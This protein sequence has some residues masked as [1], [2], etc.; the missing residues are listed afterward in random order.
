MPD[1]P[2]IPEGALSG[3]LLGGTYRLGRMIGRGGMGQVYEGVQEPLG[4]RVAV[5]ILH[6]SL[7]G[8]PVMLERF[9]REAEAAAALGH[10]NVVQVT[11]FQNIPDEGAFLVMEVLSG[12]PLNDLLESEG[13]LPQ[14]RAAFIATQV[15]SALEAAHGAGIIHRDLK[16]QNIFLTEISGVRDIVK[17]LDFGIAK[18]LEEGDR[19]RM[20]A[21]G[22]TLGTPAYMA[23][24]MVRGDELD[25]RADLYAVGAILYEMLTGR[26]PIKA[27]SMMAMFYAIMEQTPKPILALSPQVNP[28]LAH[29]VE[30]A[31]AKDP[32]DRFADASQMRQALMP[33]SRGQG[34]EAHV[35]DTVA[36]PTT[37]PRARAATRKPLLLVGAAVL[38][39]GLGAALAI[40]LS[41]SPDTPPPEA[42]NNAALDQA[43]PP[44]SR[45]QSR[46][47]NPRPPRSISS[48]RSRPPWIAPNQSRPAQRAAPG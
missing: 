32:A 11:D 33:F 19:T 24:E 10:P 28:K 38:L 9:R 12:H 47:R 2:V 25:G 5:K 40:L 31:V 18:L 30:R 23:P 45:I 4:R 42:A 15:L 1:Q 22:M 44:P 39:V 36:A 14:D 17:L 29:A 3:H 6:P 48:Q 13:T 46:S 21:T 34:L 27:P 16:P 37:L 35:P 41:G 7:T 20:T 26:T 8:D 43:K